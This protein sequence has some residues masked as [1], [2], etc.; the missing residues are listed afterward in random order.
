MINIVL[1]ILQRIQKN[2]KCQ[3]V[4]IA[5]IVVFS[6]SR[7]PFLC[8]QF[9]GGTAADSSTLPA[10]D[11]ALGISHK[12]SEGILTT[13][14]LLFSGYILLNLLSNILKVSITVACNVF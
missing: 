9:P 12:K 8:V 14:N 3:S 7:M 4:V 2:V 11:A 5:A 6:S 1:S 10:L 13:S